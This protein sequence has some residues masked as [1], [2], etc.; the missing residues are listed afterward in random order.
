MTGQQLL[1]ELQSLS[2]EQLAMEVVVEGDEGWLY[3]AARVELVKEHEGQEIEPEGEDD[4]ECV[5]DCIAIKS[6]W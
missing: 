2:P 1:Q 3:G 5:P 6:L 4:P